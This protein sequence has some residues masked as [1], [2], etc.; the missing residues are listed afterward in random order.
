MNMYVCMYVHI[1]FIFHGTNMAAQKVAL[2]T[3]TLLTLK[4]IKTFHIH[5]NY[6]YMY[7][8]VR[9]YTCISGFLIKY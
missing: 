2:K 4:L 6:I 7:T 9:K 5:T 3:L 1:I 8:Y